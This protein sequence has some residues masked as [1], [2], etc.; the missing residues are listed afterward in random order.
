MRR[1]FAFEVT[2]K[3]SGENC[4]NM[5]KA[6]FRCGPLP[7]AARDEAHRNCQLRGVRLAPGDGA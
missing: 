2:I 3:A 5:L 6:I 7:V 1:E 4:S